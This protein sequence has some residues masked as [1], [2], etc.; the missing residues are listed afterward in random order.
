MATAQAPSFPASRQPAP[1]TADPAQ[2]NP[3]Q[4]AQPATSPS[5]D[6]PQTPPAIAPLFRDWASI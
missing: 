2:G 6:A 1:A 3:G 5:A 4:V